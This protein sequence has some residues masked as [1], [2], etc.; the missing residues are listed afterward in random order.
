MIYFYTATSTDQPLDLDYLLIHIQNH[1][2]AQW[3]LYGLVI[4]VPKEF[5]KQLKD[6]C[7]EDCLAEVLDY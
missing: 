5:L 6:H 1:F 2:N 4:G 7:K 3:Y